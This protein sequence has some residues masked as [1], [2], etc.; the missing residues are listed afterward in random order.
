MDLDVR[1]FSIQLVRPFKGVTERSGL[2]IGG[3]F[4]WGECSPF[5]GYASDSARCLASAVSCATRRWPLPI[6]DKV[7]VNAT[8]SDM[9]AEDAAI[10]ALNCGCETIKIKVATELDEEV[11]EAV[12]HSIGPLGKLRVD[13]NGS[14]EI[15]TAERLIKRWDRYDLELVEQPVA[16][17]EEMARLRKL[18]SVPIAADES[19][20]GLEDAVMAARLTAVDAIVIKVQYAGG[21][22]AALRIAE[23]A[24]VPSIISSSIETSIGIATGV[25]LAAALPELPYACGL[26]TAS[27][28][29][30]DLAVPFEIVDG[31]IDVARAEPDAR[32]LERYAFAASLPGLKLSE[33]VQ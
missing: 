33:E 6:R 11:I 21:I 26:G 13:A 32:M 15:E 5:P 16:T 1:G 8:V 31:C 7:P 12:R 19:V 14:W 28:L 4:G 23:A 2:I 29:D 22:D 17:L 10:F 24:E 18:V 20:N 3:P 25:A 30:G 9:T 27:L